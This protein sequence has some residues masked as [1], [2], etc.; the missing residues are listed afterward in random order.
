MSDGPGRYDDIAT[1]ARSM[2]NAE[3]VILFIWNGNRGQGFEVQFFDPVLLRKVP[4][5]LRDMADQIEEDTKNG[6]V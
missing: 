3:G 1:I 4:E 2:T 5:I 6:E